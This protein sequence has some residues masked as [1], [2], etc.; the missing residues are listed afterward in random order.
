MLSLIKVVFTIWRKSL[1]ANAFLKI[2]NIFLVRQNAL[3]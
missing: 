3:A 1:K 2:E